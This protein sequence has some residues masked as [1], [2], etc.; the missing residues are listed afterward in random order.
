MKFKI[1]YLVGVFCIITVAVVGAIFLTSKGKG[2]VIDISIPSG[3]KA[4]RRTASVILSPGTSQNLYFH[5]SGWFM[6]KAEFRLPDLAGTD[7]EIKAL[8]TVKGKKPRTEDWSN[9]TKKIFCL[10]KRNEKVKDV[11]LTVTNNSASST[12]KEEI[13][14]FAMRDGC[15]EWSG[16]FSYEWSDKKSDKTERG[17]LQ[18]TFTL[19]ENAYATEFVVADGGYTYNSIGCSKE[20]KVKTYTML[21]E[22]ALSENVL[23]L[24]PSDD[25]FELKL[26]V[27]WGKTSN[28]T[29]YVKKNNICIYGKEKGDTVN[30]LDESAINTLSEV[31]AEKWIFTP[32]S[33]TGN[34]EGA[35]EITKT[36]DDGAERIIKVKWSLTRQ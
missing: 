8:V 26:P 23:R 29:E 28:A 35:K 32:D 4:S 3:E 1:Y 22:G 30:K 25:G 16:T 19:K 12:L 9:I 20:S 17:M 36:L 13:Q 7:F 31:L 33:L 15:D 18:A 34:L 14:A 6:K 27:V 2:S 10:N 24:V 11:V 21:G 5:K